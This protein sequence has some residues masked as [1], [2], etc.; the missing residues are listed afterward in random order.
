MNLFMLVLTHRET[1]AVIEQQY[2]TREERV[3][4]LP[5]VHEYQYRLI[6]PEEADA[7]PAT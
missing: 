6:D 7:E 4:Q 3:K 5:D 1:R 2:A